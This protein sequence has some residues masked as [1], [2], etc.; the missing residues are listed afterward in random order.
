MYLHRC[1]IWISTVIHPDGIGHRR[2]VAKN[3]SFIYRS[4]HQRLSHWCFIV[5]CERKSGL[6]VRFRLPGPR[7]SFSH[8]HVRKRPSRIV[9]RLK[10]DAIHVSFIGEFRILAALVHIFDARLPSW[11]VFYFPIVALEATPMNEFMKFD[12]YFFQLTLYL[13]HSASLK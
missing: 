13:K 12:L 7:C 10:V 5:S 8:V 4:E 3:L 1:R 9:T 6:Q 11:I 2:F